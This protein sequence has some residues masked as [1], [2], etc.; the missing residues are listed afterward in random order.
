MNRLA[1]CFRKVFGHRAG[2]RVQVKMIKR[3][4]ADVEHPKGDGPA[5]VFD[6]AGVTQLLQREQEA[7]DSRFGELDLAG[8]FLE[9][10]G[11]LSGKPL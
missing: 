9:A 3:A 6:A 5:I 4:R 2:R 11:A 1:K 7:V 10:D 8:Q